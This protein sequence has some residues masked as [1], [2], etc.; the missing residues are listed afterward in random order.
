MLKHG[1]KVR[2]P[3]T[4]AHRKFFQEIG[5]RGGLKG[6]I[7]TALNMTPEERRERAVKASRAR[8][9]KKKRKGSK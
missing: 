7:R 9:G 5:R 6:G 4:E 8:W 1:Q 3:M 2:F